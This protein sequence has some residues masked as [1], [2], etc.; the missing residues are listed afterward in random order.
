M[1][2]VLSDFQPT[3]V[4][5]LVSNFW[6]HQEGLGILELSHVYLIDQMDH[7]QANL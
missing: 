7:R 1:Q 6:W 3:Q 4:S 2:L 5:V